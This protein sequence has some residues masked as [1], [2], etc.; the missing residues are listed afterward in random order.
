MP[1]IF[2]LGII[3]FQIKKVLRGAKI[4]IIF[5]NNSKKSFI[6]DTNLLP[7]CRWERKITKT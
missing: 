6:S 5:K 3:L 4:A 7:L 2:F 1:T